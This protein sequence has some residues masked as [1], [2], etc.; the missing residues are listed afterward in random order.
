MHFELFPLLLTQARPRPGTSS[1][2]YNMETGDG[3]EEADETG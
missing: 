3:R 2:D 1:E